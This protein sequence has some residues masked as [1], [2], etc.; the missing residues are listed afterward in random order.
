MTMPLREWL[1]SDEV[2]RLMAVPP[3]DL[4]TKEFFRDPLRPLH[5]DP[6]LMYAFADGIVLYVEPNVK[7]DDWLE[8]KGK[9][10][11]LK[12]LIHDEHYNEESLVVGIF[13]T[14]Y[15]VHVNRVPAS[16]YY[17]EDRTTNTIVTHNISML[18]IEHDLFDELKFDKKDMG[19]LH[20]NERKTSVFSCPAIHGRYYLVQIGD[21]DIDV[22]CNWGKGNF[23]HQGDRFG[24]IRW[25]SQVEMVIPRKKGI[26]YEP[27]VKKLDH[28][29][30]GIDP[31]LRVHCKH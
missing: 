12:E 25:G 27:L 7:P 26:E 23:L 21:K 10:F 8:I 22:I 2:K 16:S 15:D 24:Q 31:I 5:F 18:V 4:L 28:V 6:D 30:A 3:N 1:K 19:Y 17:L 9:Q 20:T 13:M 29:E 11:T 14:S